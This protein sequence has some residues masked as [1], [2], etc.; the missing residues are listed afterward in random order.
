MEE[1][2][3]SVSA[4]EQIYPLRERECPA[5]CVFILVQFWD[6]GLPTGQLMGLDRAV[7]R[8]LPSLHGLAILGH[9]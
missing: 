9:P 2:Q 3:A 7:F 5:L 8:D 4:L 1:E 6:S